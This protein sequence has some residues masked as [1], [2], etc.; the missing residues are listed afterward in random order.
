MQEGTRF[1][2]A[3]SADSMCSPSRAGFMTGKR[4]SNQLFFVLSGQSKQTLKT[5]LPS[6]RACYFAL[7]CPQ[8]ACSPKTISDFQRGFLPFNPKSSLSAPAAG[9]VSVTQRKMLL[10]HV[11]SRK[12]E[13]IFA[14]KGSKV[15]YLSGM[16]T[17][18]L[19]RLTKVESSH[20]ARNQLSLEKFGFCAESEYQS[21]V[22][23]KLRSRIRTSFPPLL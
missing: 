23:T 9:Y 4:A 1:L 6:P 7:K 17:S 20:K 21:Q 10:R 16:G 19:F 2:N 22:A 8:T 13:Q 12:F 11:Q 15:G 5:A 18:C 3:Y 14:Q